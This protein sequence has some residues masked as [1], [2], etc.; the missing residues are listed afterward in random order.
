MTKQH[1]CLRELDTFL[2]DKNTQ[3]V[4]DLL[5]P[6]RVFIAT[7]KIRNLRDGKHAV[8]VIASFCPIC[9]RRLNVDAT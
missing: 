9:G 6:N 8:Q 4:F 2:K 5:H 1:K 7:Q 3:L